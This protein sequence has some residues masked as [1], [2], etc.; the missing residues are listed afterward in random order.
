MKNLSLAYQIWI[1][2]AG[3]TVG[4]FL[5]L[6]LIIP[7][8]LGS[9]FTRETF[10][11]IEHAQMNEF[12]RISGERSI[13]R[14]IDR[15]LQQPSI[16]KDQE[17]QSN[18]TV[19]HLL[20]TSDGRVN[21]PGRNLPSSVML[22]IREQALQ[23]SEDSKQYIS[24]IDGKKLY[25]IIRQ[26]ISFQG[27]SAY[28]ISYMWDT[29]HDQMVRSLNRQLMLL[30]ALVTLVSWLP[31]VWLAK[32]LS[33][34]LVRLQEHV[35][36]IAHRKWH[37]PIQLNRQDEFGQLASSIDRM[38]EQLRRQDETQQSLLQ[39][40]SHELKTPV[41]V[42][43]SYAQS[44]QDGIYPRGDLASSVE[45]IDHESQRLEKRIRDLL[46]LTKLDYLSTTL[47]HSEEWFDLSEL[48]V[49]VSERLRWRR[50][51]LEWKMDLPPLQIQGDREQWQVALENL[52]DNQM[53]YAVSR[54]EL[55]LAPNA[56]PAMEHPPALP[57]AAAQAQQ[58]GSMSVN[59]SPAVPANPK[60]PATTDV[61]SL[62]I[63]NDG[64]PI[65]PG[66][67][68]N[69]FHQFQKGY[70]GE[71]GLGLAIVQRIATLHGSRVWAEN[72]PQGVSFWLQ[73]PRPVKGK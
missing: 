37:D 64:P 13:D 18:R 59:A 3:I 36:Q 31:S 48:A 16:E 40:I 55:S 71:F 35:K 44:I 6:L 33:R 38:R 60:L 2:L 7:V 27:Q 30:M 45:V 73:L 68:E 15:F 20:M 66:V 32:Y 21:F 54:I 42:I 58:S 22:D 56:S 46:Y 47:L 51:E 10:A 41:M 52:L 67:M 62:R 14:N 69:L 57:E 53:R 63:W 5:L 25:Y 43:R 12:P 8:T 26:N 39:H 4:I 34:P 70:K 9:F 72:D 17:N 61:P 11:N 24:S 50:P 29:Y 65:D 28:L 23:Q 49:H 19:S 1:V